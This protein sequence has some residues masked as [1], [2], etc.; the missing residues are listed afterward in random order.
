MTI[1]VDLIPKPPYPQPVLLVDVFYGS[2]V[3]ML[4]AAG[5]K[6][7][8]V[9]KSVRAARILAEGG[10]LLLGEEE[11][12]PPEGFHN[13]LSLVA[14]GKQRF[15]AQ[16]CVLLAKPLA[17]SLEQLPQG[18]ALAYF[19]NARQAIQ[20]AV[21]MQIDTV[22]AATQAKLEPSLANTVAA[23]FLAKRLHQALGQWGTLQDGARLAT[24]LLK[25]FPD[26]QESLVQSDLGK[27]LYRV[28]RSE[29]LALASLVSVEERVPRLTQV[30]VLKADQYGLSKDRFGFCFQER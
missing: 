15:Q 2:A 17:E 11:G 5:V 30:R 14:L 10:S 6:E 27:Q 29:D 23:G 16:S 8:W 21:D 9:A 7:V 19:R 12:L 24:A 18:S 25:S 4:L 26:P 20:Y 22:V 13:G 3:G 28:G 1:R